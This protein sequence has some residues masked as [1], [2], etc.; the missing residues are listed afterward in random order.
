[1][2][3][4]PEGS[5]P[6]GDRRAR[7]KRPAP[8]TID[9]KATEV[10]SEPPPAASAASPPSGEASASDE[11][12]PAG[13]S[14]SATEAARGP[15][16]E[17]AAWVAVPEPPAAV[18]KVESSTDTESS[19]A[20]ADSDQPSDATGRP[21]EPPPADAPTHVP[22]TT[23]ADE[24]PPPSADASPPASR[25]PPA[26][27]VP[28]DVG[29]AGDFAADERRRPSSWPL[30]VAIAAA[31]LL[32]LAGVLLGSI[33]REDPDVGQRL[34]RMETQLAR[35]G[36]RPADAAAAPE[37]AARVAAAEQAVRRLDE[38]T[39]RLADQAP[40]RDDTRRPEPEQFDALSARLDKLEQ[41][42]AAPRPEGADA[43][44]S[45]RLAA[46][47]AAAKTVSERV[48]AAEAATAALAQRLSAAGSTEAAANDRLAAAVTAVRSLTERVA[49][50]GLR[51]EEATRLAR[52]AERQGALASE[53]AANR[54][55]ESDRSVRLA[56][57]AAALRDAV[58]RGE[59][60][61]AELAAA[62]PLARDPAELAP[63]EP[64][65]ATGV[66]SAAALARDLS[67]LVPTLLKRTQPPAREGGVLEALQA[68]AER[69]VRIRRI[70]EPPGDDAG[71][72]VAR[73]EAQAARGDVD[74]AAA[75]LAKL[76]PDLRAPA[77]PWVKQAQ[78]RR[79]AHD[80]ANRLAHDAAAALGKN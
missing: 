2:A 6:P 31:L 44:L 38:L 59:P 72:I 28:P 27:P 41:A 25:L 66:P 50:L 33:R 79:A 69:L 67:A 68:S 8:P 9:L 26:P 35:L 43:G 80:A 40:P 74:A 47:E 13:D 22:P 23:F 73:I 56:F 39:A 24:S 3:S 77:D 10:P 51:V 29:A 58:A 32:A 15:Q 65:A 57:V 46:A 36:E 71:A 75:E 20:A 37:L 60:F 19:V 55:V 14:A 78:A 76:P 53:Q 30:W 21:A 5:S 54:L 42:A 11:V 49:D 45:E 4:T 63:L 52:A 16:S 64:F 1:M 70:D 12:S 17:E 34:A 61:A 62:K 7:R 18:S 48:A